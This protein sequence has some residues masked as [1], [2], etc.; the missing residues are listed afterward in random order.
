MDILHQIDPNLNSIALA[1]PKGEMFSHNRINAIKTI[2]K[3]SAAYNIFRKIVHYISFTFI[4]CNWKLDKDTS[5]ILNVMQGNMEIW[6][7][8]RGD[9]DQNDMYFR[10]VIAERIISFEDKKVLENS[11]INLSKIVKENGG[12][13]GKKIDL[14]L[15][16]IENIVTLP[17]AQDLQNIGL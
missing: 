4:P 3:R 11:V 12:S 2:N 1:Y 7:A 17:P 8:Y 6:L 9:G 15:N 14:L 5:D 10:Y 13:K 16:R